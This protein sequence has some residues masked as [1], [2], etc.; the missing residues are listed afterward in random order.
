MLIYQIH[1][2]TLD[3]MAGHVNIHIIYAN[4][5]TYQYFFIRDNSFLGDASL[6]QTT[7]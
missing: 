3:T 1:V 5:L 2:F 6:S 4:V 7:D